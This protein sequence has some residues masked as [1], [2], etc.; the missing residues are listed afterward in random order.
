MDERLARWQA[1][2]YERLKAYEVAGLKALRPSLENMK[3]WDQHLGHPHRHYPILHIAGTNGKGSTAAFLA[4]ILQ[5]AGYRVG[6]HTSPH[7]FAFTERMRINGQEPPIEWVD[8]FLKAHK[9]FILA[10]NLSFFEVTVGMSL[11]WFAEAAVDI[12]LVEVGLG[13]RW[14]ATNVVTPEVAIITPI[15][16]DH[17]EILGPTLAHIAQEK[18]GIIKPNRPLVIAP[19]QQPIALTV[20]TEVARTVSA[21][22]FIAPQPLTP[23]DW[24]K[25]GRSLYRVFEDPTRQRLY[26]SNLGANYQGVNIAT[27]LLAIEVLKAQ[28]WRIDEHAITYGLAEAANL[29]PLWGRLQWVWNGDQL[30]L[31][32]VAHNPH[33]LRALLESLSTLPHLPNAIILGFSREKDIRTCLEIIKEGRSGSLYLTAAQNPRALPPESLEKAAYDIGLKPD[34]VFPTALDALSYSLEAGQTPL[35]TGSLFLVADALKAL[36]THPH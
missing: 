1:W 12:A 29:A 32:D 14:D 3:K 16:W 25:E 13:G 36:W 18:A 33:G 23:K 2:L 4:A 19:S 17:V 11:A 22:Y 28:G 10:H 21:P 26:K 15:D 8:Q 35:V 24:L 5:T 27:A 30:A 31:L 7:F 6:L 20:L 34:R 9:A